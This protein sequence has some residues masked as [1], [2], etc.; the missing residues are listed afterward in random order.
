MHCRAPRT[1]SLPVLRHTLAVVLPPLLVERAVEGCDKV[2]QSA[3]KPGWATDR[4]C[5][6]AWWCGTATCVC[7][8]T[9][10]LARV[11]ARPLPPLPSKLWRRT[12]ECPREERGLW[13]QRQRPQGRGGTLPVSA[14][15]LG[16][17]GSVASR[18]S[19]RTYVVDALIDSLRHSSSK[20]TG[21]SGAGI[22]VQHRHQHQHKAPAPKRVQCKR[23]GQALHRSAA[24]PEQA[25]IAV[26]S[27][28]VANSVQK[29]RNGSNAQTAPQPYMMHYLSVLPHRA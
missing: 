9:H 14:Q 18:G 2:P 25:A 26:C 11:P 23:A 6:V 10:T 22:L 12:G 4:W 29:K 16:R 21:R 27:A 17:V 19:R 15:A 20:H 8:G 28:S 1:S 13:M 24:A 5:G 7:P 3:G